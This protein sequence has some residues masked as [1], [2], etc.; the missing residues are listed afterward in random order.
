MI[1][2]P[3]H[4]L[5]HKLIKL[6]ILL[7]LAIS[8]LIGTVQVSLDYMEHSEEKALIVKKILDVAAHTATRAVQTSD[9][10]LADHTIAGL[11]EYPFIVQVK[12]FD[13]DNQ[14]LGQRQIAP[15]KSA[16]RFITR[17][18][19][20]EFRDYLIPL[21]SIDST[22]KRNLGVL[23]ITVDQD[24]LFTSFYS[25]A[26]SLLTGNFI[27]LLILTFVLLALFSS[28]V[29]QP[30]ITI[31][32]KIRLIDPR[33]PEKQRLLVEN[34]NSDDE[35]GQLVLSCNKFIQATEDLITER[36]QNETALLRNEELLVKTNRLAKVGGWDYSIE[37][38]ELLWSKELCNILGLPAGYELDLNDIYNRIDLEHKPSVEKALSQSVKSGDPFDIKF[39]MVRADNKNI[40][41]RAIG[42]ATT[43]KG[44]PVW[45]SGIL[46]DN[47]EN[48]RSEQ[49][50]MLRDFALNQTPDSILTIDSSGTVVVA[51]DTTCERYGYTR[52][53]LIGQ[54]VDIFNPD[55]EMTAWDKWW[56]AVKTN[57]KL[58]TNTYN[59]TKAGERFP[60]EIS[61]GYFIYDDKEFC[62][63]SIKDITE[64]KQQ[65]EEIQHLA[66]HDILTGLPNRSLLQDRLR[67]AITT[68]RRHQY[69]GAL[70]FIDLD[71]FKK[72]NDSLGHPTGDEVLKELANRFT[73][74][75]RD[76]DTVARLG[77]DEFVVILPYLSADIEE[78]DQKA[79]GFAEKLLD[80][81]SLPHHILG[82]ELQVTASIGMVLFPDAAE[83]ADSILQFA[84]TAMYQAKARGRA[85]ITRFTAE[86][87][88]KAS[89]QLSLEN[90]L[91]NALNNEEYLLYVQ[92]Q[93]N[94]Q[95]RLIG[96]EIL[97]RWN[98]PTIGLVSPTEFIPILESTGMVFQVG[99][100]V[101][102]RACQQIKLWLDQEI[103]QDGLTLAVNISPR[104]FRRPQFVNE[105]SD[106][107]QE[108]DIPQRHL[109]I[110]ITEGMVIHNIEE[111][112]EK[113]NHIRELGVMVSIDDFGMGYSSLSYLKK[114]PIDTLKIDQSFIRDLPNDLDDAAIVTA[115]IA[116]AKQL[117]LRVIA[118]GVEAKQQINFLH[119]NDCLEFQGYY[120]SK[121]MPI[122]EFESLLLT[123]QTDVISPL[124]S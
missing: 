78:A 52:E 14:Q 103:W 85:N 93:Y 11:L 102:R 31:A 10:A 60:V 81:V 118:E 83:S 37:T 111:I 16:T 124:A 68:A 97:L 69:I 82:H 100:W 8:L 40:W 65:D 9:K 92:P 33:A 21:E 3:R 59:S 71:D 106:I 72:I 4:S 108:T 50:L 119:E 29:T 5:S 26:F 34:R 123:E 117:N 25:H 6:S 107:L 122:S 91:R 63:M 48:R 18:L 120:F 86:M 54:T 55:F 19:D 24:V 115:I 94:Y 36:H 13:I 41:V 105:V 23:S 90:Q 51:N 2:K 39:S 75:L 32:E 79:L 116:M 42:L 20:T 49:A 62:I 44:K 110:E 112:V 15:R 89:R 47:T 80:L 113:L 35:L 121:P 22:P 101:I 28:Y 17:L 58:V 98:S 38:G 109:E 96:A 87:T 46:Q 88:T 73:A 53:E 7:A 45:F 12:I 61:T 104:Q 30:L 27:A 84:D 77:G 57:E 95:N 76:E 74:N 114:L 67:L 99:E 64:R 1:R 43:H 56:S 70:L 66:Y